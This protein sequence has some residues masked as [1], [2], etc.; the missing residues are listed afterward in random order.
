MIKKAASAIFK[1]IILITLLNFIIFAWFAFTPVIDTVDN[2]PVYGKMPNKKPKFPPI[3]KLARGG[4]PFCTAFVIDANYAL[5]AAHCISTTGGRLQSAPIQ[6]FLENDF[7]TKV[8]ALA[9]AVNNRMDAGLIKG[10]FSNFFLLKPE[11]YEYTIISKFDPSDEFR[12]CG[13]P[14]GQKHLTCVP[15]FPRTNFGFAIA[16]QGFM[17]PGM[18]G[19]PLIHRQTG[20]VVGINIAMGDG[21]AFVSSTMGLLGAFKI[22]P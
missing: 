6:I 14:W 20:R 21:W 1:F 11:F 12:T 8:L 4:K 17:L 15:F 13:Y 18:S 5:T 9:A 16:G 19:G 22:E 7:D 10:D 2:L 3:V